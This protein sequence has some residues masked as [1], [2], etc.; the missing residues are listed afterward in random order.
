MDLSLIKYHIQE[1]HKL[2]QQEPINPLFFALF[3]DLERILGS[4]LFNN[5]KEARLAPIW[6]LQTQR[7][8]RQVIENLL[9]EI[10]RNPAYPDEVKADIAKAYQ[11]SMKKYHTEIKSLRQ[12]QK[13]ATGEAG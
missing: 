10:Q 13:Q 3:S 4:Q 8:Q 12:T 2:I 6:A 11:E 5:I 1:L 7:K 9:K